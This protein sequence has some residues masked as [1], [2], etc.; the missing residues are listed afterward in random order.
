[1]TEPA[2]P[3]QAPAPF[4]AILT[5]HRSL[6]AQGFL[7]VMAAI[8]LVSFLA[9]MAFLVMG[10]WPVFGFFGLDVALIYFAFRANYRA[11]RQ[12]ETVE[13][14]RDAVTLTHVDASGRTTSQSFNPFWV[15]VEIEQ[16]TDGRAFLKL[17]ES[18]RQSLFGSFLLDEEKHELADAL[19]AA[20][21]T[22]RGRR[23]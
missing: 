17:A 18:G 12:F 15:R 21:L 23:I 9:G 10:A 14:T 1:M 3:A 7:I 22:A 16:W 5:P 4:R 8:G 6:S 11:A 19:R 13:V 20:L 2:P